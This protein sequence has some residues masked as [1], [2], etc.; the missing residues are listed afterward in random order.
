[1]PSTASYVDDK[2]SV[3]AVRQNSTNTGKT[4]CLLPKA[5]DQRKG[6]AN[7]NEIYFAVNKLVGL[8]NTAKQKTMLFCRMA[9][10]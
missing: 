7:Q 5:T 4:G 6:T 1:M 10:W 3:G 9:G 8:E 2:G